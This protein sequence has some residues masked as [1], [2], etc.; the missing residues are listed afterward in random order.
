MFLI[1]LSESLNIM[2]LRS[3]SPEHRNLG[4]QKSDNRNQVVSA[5]GDLTGKT[6]MFGGFFWSAA[7]K[8]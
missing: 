8:N 4:F 7:Q 3:S 6:A 1:E 2:G 5:K